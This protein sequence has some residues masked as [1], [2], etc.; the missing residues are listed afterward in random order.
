VGLFFYLVLFWAVAA[1]YHEYLGGKR[2]RA[3][4]RIK[5]LL[6]MVQERVAWDSDRLSPR[7]LATLQGC[8]EKLKAALAGKA[9]APELEALLEQAGGQYARVYPRTRQQGLRETLELIVVVFGVV[10]GLRGLLV[11]PFKIPTGSM[12]PTLYGIHFEAMDEAPPSGPVRRLMDYVNF[13]RRYVEATVKTPGELAGRGTT[14]GRFLPTT[15]LTVGQEQFKLPGEWHQVERYLEPPS[16]MRDRMYQA[17]DALARGALVAGD[18]LF[19]DRV[20]YQFREPRRG[21]VAVF[22]TTG[23]KLPGG[24]ALGGPF[25]IKR[26]VGLPGDTLQIREERLYV[27]AAGE[28]EFR[29]MDG[30]MHKGFERMYSFQGGYRGYSHPL[31]GARYLL[32]DE[33]TMTLGKDEFLM[34][35]DNSESSSDG[36][37]FGAVPRRNIVGRACFVWWPFSR[38]WGLVD[39]AEPEAVPTLPTR[40]LREQ[41]GLLLL[42]A[43]TP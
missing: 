40:L 12:Q 26:L 41:R 14:K 13:G 35:G 25:Y 36:R 3:R 19:V 20:T 31:G 30:A 6:T 2:H 33:A 5:G 18:Y 43:G 10:A 42:P 29:L 17:G 9:P 23:L 11:Q 22:V 39:K 34:L 37:Y 38:R 8:Q 7:D 27:K 15:T 4:H 28:S 16:D 24:G 21:D 1:L 32:D